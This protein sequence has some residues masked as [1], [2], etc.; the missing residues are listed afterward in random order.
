MKKSEVN[1]VNSANPFGNTPADLDSSSYDTEAIEHD[2]TPALQP[3]PSQN[4]LYLK[5]I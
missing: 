2:V 3:E 1:T 4:N 5:G